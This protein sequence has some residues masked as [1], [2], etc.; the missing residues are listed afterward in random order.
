MCLPAC[1][2]IQTGVRSVFSPLAARNNRGSCVSP[3]MPTGT[4]RNQLVEAGV[5]GVLGRKAQ[6]QERYSTTKKADIWLLSI[7]A[8]EE[9]TRALHKQLRSCCSMYKF[10][11]WV[12][13]SSKSMIRKSSFSPVGCDHCS[14]CSEVSLQTVQFFS[15]FI[16]CICE[17]SFAAT[18]YFLL[19]C[20]PVL[21]T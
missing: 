16:A 15:T 19:L 14:P 9:S 10:N 18:S 12:L 8:T 11:G 20:F 17:T 21:V 13:S 4:A 3:A 7:I 6:A 5:E 1:L 2:I